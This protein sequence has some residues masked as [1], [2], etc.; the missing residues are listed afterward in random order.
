[1]PRR[2]YITH[3]ATTTAGGKVTSATSFLS[4]NGT[5]VALEGDT[6]WCAQCASDGVIGRDGPRLSM[7]CN[8]RQY[9]LG[10]DLCLCKC[11]PAP[12]MVATQTLS[13]QEIDAD[14]HAELAAAA[15]AAAARANAAAASPARDDRVPFVLR[16]L[17]TGEVLRHCPYRLDLSGKDVRGTTDA[18]GATRP[19]TAA[20]RA[21]FVAWQVDHTLGDA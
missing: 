3:D 19:L 21:S 11:S 5:A 14:V 7:T 4:I 10:G 13:S 17:Q 2:Y 16:D 18:N 12:R 8:D 6:V 15:A 1:M 20:E 9:A